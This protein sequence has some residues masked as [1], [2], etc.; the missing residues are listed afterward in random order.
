MYTN[1]LTPEA[2][3]FL[4]H[5]ICELIQGKQTNNHMAATLMLLNVCD[6][7]ASGQEILN[8]ELLTAFCVV[9]FRALFIF[10]LL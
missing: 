1:I 9:L 8:L 2:L 5:L 6:F 10:V 4:N 7:F 3:L